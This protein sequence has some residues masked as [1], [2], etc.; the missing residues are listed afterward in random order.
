M[1]IRDSIIHAST[2]LFLKYGVKSVS[3]D[4]IARHIGVSK[5]TIY[6]FIA[7]KKDLVGV[8]VKA[9]IEEEK[10][11]IAE[12]S[13][14]SASAVA[15]MVGIANFAL[16]SLR[17]MNPSMVYDLKKYHNQ[18]WQIIQKEHF[19]FI[20]RIIKDNITRGIEEGF[21]RAE[22]NSTIISKLYVSIGN[23]MLDQDIFPVEM[24]PRDKLYENIVT[25]HLFGI[26]NPRGIKEFNKIQKSQGQ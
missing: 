12:I 4:D 6:T 21:Y 23:L 14:T 26:L 2:R 9:Y 7:N 13:K 15:E 3:M 1:N 19:Q 8:V 20:E 18:S 5:K 22:L 25:Y 10:K 11:S 24:Y 17:S 16:Q